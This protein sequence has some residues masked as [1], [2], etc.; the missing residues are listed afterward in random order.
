[1][2]C[3]LA[4]NVAAVGYLERALALDPSHEETRVR[5]AETLIARGDAARALALVKGANMSAALL[6][7]RIR[8]ASRIDGAAAAAARRE[9][10]DLLAIGQRR[11]SG[12]HLREEGELAL[13]VDGDASHALD[14][15]RRNFAAQ[16][17]TPDLR[18]LVDAA[19]AARDPQALAFA[20]SWLSSTGFEDRVVL[21]RLR[22]AGM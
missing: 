1:M 5:L 8:A 15:A 3:A 22:E 17:D 18:L 4:M 7:A 20:R 6:V 12:S 14:L 19:I 13:H 11:G 2:P 16:K 21:E 10:E 9:F